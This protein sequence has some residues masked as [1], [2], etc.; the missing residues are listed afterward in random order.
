M[1]RSVHSM[2]IIPFRIFELIICSLRGETVEDPH[3]AKMKV[4]QPLSRL[5]FYEVITLL[6]GL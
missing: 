1:A 5:V 4:N 2:F 3:Y 6:P